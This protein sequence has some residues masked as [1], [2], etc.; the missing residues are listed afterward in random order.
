[1][2]NSALIFLSAASLQCVSASLN[3]QFT[4]N[5]DAHLMK[6]DDFNSDFTSGSTAAPIIELY[7]GSEKQK[8]PIILDTGS[9]TPFLQ[10]KKVSEDKGFDYEKSSSY[11]SLD[12]DFS[13]AYAD[14]TSYT[15]N[16]SYDN[17]ANTEDGKSFNLSFGLV[18]DAET[19]G[20]SSDTNIFGLGF[21]YSDPT[22]LDSLKENDVI[23]RKLFSI[24]SSAN[25]HSL[26]EISFGAI[27]SAKYT[28]DFVSV[29]LREQ[30]NGYVWWTYMT[31]LSVGCQSATGDN[32][33]YI[34]F[35][36]GYTTG[37]TIPS[38]LKQKL[39]NNLDAYYESS[40][41]N[42]VFDC[43]K[44]TPLTVEVMGHKIE[45][46]ASAIT[47][48]VK[49]S[50]KCVLQ[51]INTGSEK[52]TVYF[53][54]VFF[55]YIYPVFDAQNKEILF[56][57]P[58]S[59]TSD[60]DIKEVS[61]TLPSASKAASYSSVSAVTTTKSIDTTSVSTSSTSL[62]LDSTGVASDSVSTCGNAK[63][64]VTSIAAQLES[65]VF[66]AVETGNASNSS[67]SSSA[68]VSQYEDAGSKLG[69]TSVLFLLASL[70]AL[71]I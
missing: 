60:S 11:H 65:F 52:D 35:D 17:V 59:D 32:I 64:V 13:V 38:V 49:N 69:S 27:D 26:G 24:Y 29:P 20:V 33:Y 57:D 42:Y 53:G 37:V 36:C 45:I 44:A 41:Q 31:D 25:D 48:K 61:D 50:D 21:D 22:M 14:S 6:R 62:D 55:P 71:L 7:F 68:P 2:V 12:K 10:S 66:R 4:P 3:F 34:S 28:G 1:M 19:N 5:N 39:V 54:W 18:T 9:Y 40:S 30:S 23:S 8:I 46:P 67:A 15:G 47:K 70:F 58:V 63:A 56:A 43:D 16:W 51:N